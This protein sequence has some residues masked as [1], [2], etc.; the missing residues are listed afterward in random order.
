LQKPSMYAQELK[1]I[2]LFI[3]IA[4]LVHY[5]DTIQ[6]WYRYTGMLLQTACCRPVKSWRTIIDPVRPL[7]SINRVAWGPILSLCTSA[8]IIV[9]SRV[10]WPSVWPTVHT[11]WSPVS[12]GIVNP[13]TPY[14]WH[15][16]YCKLFSKCLSKPAGPT[17]SYIC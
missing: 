10:L 16:W 5:P 12:K 17:S 13:P 11:T 7:R 2:W 3:V 14:L 8:Q 9:L 15:S 1:S 6:N 4:T